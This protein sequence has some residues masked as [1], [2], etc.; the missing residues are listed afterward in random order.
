MGGGKNSRQTVS[1]AHVF[2]DESFL[3]GV[4]FCNQSGISSPHCF[5]TAAREYEEEEE[6][7]REHSEN[8]HQHS[9]KDPV[10]LFPFGRRACVRFLACSCNGFLRIGVERG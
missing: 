5:W 1:L 3:L 6:Q 7:G 8:E 10:V 9:E 2:V 4:G